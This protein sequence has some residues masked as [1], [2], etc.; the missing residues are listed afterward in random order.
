M[1]HSDHYC[2]YA[3]DDYVDI[4]ND[5]GVTPLQIATQTQMLMMMQH[6]TLS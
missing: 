2:Y 1:K 6:Q 4:N 3:Y 5:H